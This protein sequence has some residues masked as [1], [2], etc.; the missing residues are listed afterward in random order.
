MDFLEGVLENMLRTIRNWV[1]WSVIVAVRLPDIESGKT[2]FLI[3][4]SIS[5]FEWL[6]IL[7]GYKMQKSFKKEFDAR[8]SKNSLVGLW[9]L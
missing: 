4:L 5:V 7:V 9:T 6:V 8:E 1:R 2:I 3:M